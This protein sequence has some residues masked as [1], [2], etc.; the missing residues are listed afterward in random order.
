MEKEKIQL[1]KCVEISY[2]DWYGCFHLKMLL[3][4]RPVGWTKSK[5]ICILLLNCCLFSFLFIPSFFVC[6]IEKKKKWSRRHFEN[7]KT[8]RLRSC[9]LIRFS[10][11]F[12]RLLHA[13]AAAAAALPIYIHFLSVI[14]YNK[15]DNEEY[16]ARETVPERHASLDSWMTFSSRCPCCCC[17]LGDTLTKKKIYMYVY[18]GK[19]IYVDIKGIASVQKKE[20]INI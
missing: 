5:N 10:S 1:K 20:R 13:A 4:S 2:V 16:A 18:R 7:W 3:S 11:A 6:F 14:L 12:L 9:G 17:L 15:H 8:I 19:Y